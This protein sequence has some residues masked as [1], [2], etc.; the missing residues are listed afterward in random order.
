LIWLVGQQW[1][2][3]IHLINWLWYLLYLKIIDEE[4]SRQGCLYHLGPKTTPLTPLKII[5]SSPDGPHILL[6]THTLC[7]VWPLLHSNLS[8]FFLFLTLVSFNSFNPFYIPPTAGKFVRI[9]WLAAH[10][11]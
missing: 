10:L 5:F 6:L 2:P 1:H 9:V 3:R 8:S 7:F 4:V 11:Q